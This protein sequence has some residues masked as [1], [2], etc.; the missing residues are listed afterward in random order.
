MAITT[1]QRIVE[2]WPSLT[3]S[4]REALVDMAETVAKPGA[5]LQLTN[6]EAAA[7]ARS[8]DDFTAGRTFS[9]AEADAATDAFL[10][11][12]RAKA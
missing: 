1:P 2:L 11:G 7:L 6:E 3:E 8:I 12:L 4:Q 9:L 5:L 10:R